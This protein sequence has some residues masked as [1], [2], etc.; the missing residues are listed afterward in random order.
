MPVALQVGR[1]ILTGTQWGQD[2][3]EERRQ[4]QARPLLDLVPSTCV[5]SSA[6]Q[7][8]KPLQQSVAAKFIEMHANQR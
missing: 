2:L 4:D 1:D 5:H 8:M 6:W 7:Q 3:I